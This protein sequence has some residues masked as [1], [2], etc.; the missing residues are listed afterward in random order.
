MSKDDTKTIMV[1]DPDEDFLGWADKHLRTPN[2]DVIC[3]NDSKVALEQYLEQHPDLLITELFVKPLQGMDLIKKIRLNDPNAQ[4]ILTTAFPPSSA[5]IEAMRLGAY[6]VLRK[7]SLPYDLRPVVEEALKAGEEIKSTSASATESKKADGPDETIIGRSS[8]MQ[9][10]FKMVG[11]A[12]RGDAPVLITGES[13]AGKEIV[14]GAIHKFSKRSGSEF[15]AINCAAIPEN[16]LES[17]LFGHEKG[18]FTGAHSLRK[19]RF[20]Q[21]DGGTL[22]LDEIGDMPIHTQSK[23]LRTL[24]SGEFSRVGGNENLTADVRILA[25]TNKDLEFCVKNGEFRE[26]LFYRLNVVRVHI[27]PLRQRIEDIKL[28]AE[29]FLKRNAEQKKAPKLRLSS[30][31]IELLEAYHW[32]GNVRELENTLY[33]ASLLSTA[34]V[35]LPKDIPLGNL[36][37]DNI[38]TSQN[39]ESTIKESISTLKKASGKK[40]L[41][42][43]IETEF[44]KSSFLEHEKDLDLTSNFLGISVTRLK[45]LLKN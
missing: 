33:R 45:E 32:P 16:L 26:D 27:P 22:F 15:I 44:A 8:A 5:V 37:S 40:P 20:E 1:V 23:I 21:C 25:A 18:A 10:V 6:D 3:I 35:L 11:R 43:W 31:S 34:D 14:A 7:E 13:G 24:Q 36:D 29:F 4:V 9:S 41:M 30:E 17:E 39:L 42:A 28:L 12:S 38:S 19:G 2:T